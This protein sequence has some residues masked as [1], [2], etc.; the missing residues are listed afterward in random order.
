MSKPMS[1]A[2]IDDGVSGSLCGIT[3]RGSSRFEWPV[4]DALP[5]PTGSRQDP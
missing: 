2:S 4:T 3:D 1:V 5:F